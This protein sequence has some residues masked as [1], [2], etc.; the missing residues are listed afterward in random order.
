MFVQNPLNTRYLET[1]YRTGD[2]AFY[3]EKAGLCF[4]GRKD[5]QI[6]HMGHRIE[7][8]EIEAVL[9]SYPLIERAC[10][11]FD[12]EKNKITA[13]YVG[14]MNERE[15]SIRMRESLPVYMI[16]SGFCP[17]PELPVTPNGKMDRKKLLEMGKGKQP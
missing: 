4:A 16:P 1:I 14:N 5:F 11:V 9:N 2:L 6:K 7:L 12:D 13:F 15:I 3:Q 8:E 17:L 10:C